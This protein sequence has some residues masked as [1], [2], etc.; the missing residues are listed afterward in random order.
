MP[1]TTRGGPVGGEADREEDEDEEEEEEEAARTS[2]A[3]AFAS[4]TVFTTS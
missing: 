3:A 4:D 2:R 1:M